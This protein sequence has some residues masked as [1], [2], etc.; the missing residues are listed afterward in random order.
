MDED[1]SNVSTSQAPSTLGIGINTVGG[2][3]R[4]GRAIL[5]VVLRAYSH[6]V[7]LAVTAAAQ[8]AFMIP[9]RTANVSPTVM[10]L[11]GESDTDTEAL[12]TD[13]WHDANADPGKSSNR[14]HEKMVGRPPRSVAA[15]K[16]TIKRDPSAV[17]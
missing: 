7:Q 8:T 16:L 2:A 5:T 1:Q 4:L 11:R 12:S 17:N 14:E 6:V 9:G 3:D 15:S 10:L 13:H